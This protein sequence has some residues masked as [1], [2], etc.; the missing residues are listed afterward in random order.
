MSEL[1]LVLDVALSPGRERASKRALPGLASV[2]DRCGATR[3]VEVTD[4]TGATDITDTLTRSKCRRLVRG[5]CGFG[6]EATGQ[7]SFL[8][9]NDPIKRYEHVVKATA[10]QWLNA[11]PWYAIAALIVEQ[12]R[13]CKLPI[14][15]GLPSGG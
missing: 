11:Q 2:L 8:D 1:R 14:P 5:D 15:P 6:H 13:A 12:I 10:A 9:D 3:V 7:L 4:A